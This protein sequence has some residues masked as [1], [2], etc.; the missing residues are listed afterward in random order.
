MRTFLSWSGGRSRAVAEAFG[1]WLGLV[2]QSVDPWMSADIRKGAR[3]LE[4][5]ETA[6][7][8]STVGI[9]FVTKESLLSPWLHFE[10]GSIFRSKDKLVCSFLV[11]VSAEALHSLPLEHFQQTT[12]SEHDVRKLLSDI[13]DKVGAMN[14]RNLG[15]TRLNESFNNSWPAL[16]RR[17]A[18]IQ[19]ATYEDEVAD[20]GGKSFDVLGEVVAN[21]FSQAPE[22]RLSAE[23]LALNLARALQTSKMFGARKQPK[24]RHPDIQELTLLVGTIQDMYLPKLMRSGYVTKEA[25]QYVLTDGGRRH[26][27][28]EAKSR[29]ALQKRLEEMLRNGM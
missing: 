27:T 14:E 11:D 10:A 24:T 19:S 9:F 3:W 1:N 7:K 8:E 25:D 5:L 18:A 22:G 6:L 12:T 20:P 26:F 28:E 15:E 13:N 4:E 21:V 16:R 2:I 29:A 17:L 23:R